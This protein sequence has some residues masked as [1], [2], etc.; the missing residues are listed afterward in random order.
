MPRR[1]EL[2]RNGTAFTVR[3]LFVRPYLIGDTEDVEKALYLRH[4]GAGLCSRARRLC[5]G[6]GPG[7]RC[8]NLGDTS[9][10]DA[11]RMPQDLVAD[12]MIAWL[13]K[14]EVMAPMTVERSCVPSSSLAESENSEA[15]R[16]AYCEFVAEAGVFFT[17]YQPKSVYFD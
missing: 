6:I 3:P 14:A 16:T 17:G 2:E 4:S 15:L 12:E 8:G 13:N 11:D 5:F 10:N 7:W 1:I 9:V